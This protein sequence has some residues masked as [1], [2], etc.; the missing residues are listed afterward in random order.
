MPEKPIIIQ[1]QIAA[2]LELLGLRSGDIVLVHSSLSSLGFVEG[3]PDAV[4]DALLETLGPHGTLLMPS[5]QQGS[6]YE[7]LR[8]GCTFD[9]RTSPSELGIITEIFRRRPG[10]IRSVSPT[11]CVAGIG[12]RAGELLADHLTCLVSVGRGSPYDNLVR[13]EGRILLLGVT[14]TTNTTLHL[15]ENTNGAPTVCREL[16]NGIVIDTQGQSWTVPT[17]PHMPGLRRRY[18]RVEEEL[19]GASIQR[20]GYVGQ[21]LSRLIEAKP[22]AELI[23]KKIQDTPLY[24]CDVFNP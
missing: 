24:L 6:E 10:V 5:F 13:A 1:N 3:G 8:R 9:L 14:H 15:I 2:D 20:N 7:L 22:M 21:A 11:H 23:G 19:L 12:P 17:H 18:E 4:I 16:F